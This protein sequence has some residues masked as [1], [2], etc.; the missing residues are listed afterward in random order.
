M[1]WEKQ[2]ETA[3]VL[4]LLLPAWLGPVSAL[5]T[6]GHQGMKQQMAKLSL[7]LTFK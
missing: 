3:Q 2:Q 4:G 5:A 6:C 7:A 1:A